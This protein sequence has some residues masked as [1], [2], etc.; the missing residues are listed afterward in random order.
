[1]IEGLES[2]LSIWHCHVCEVMC[3]EECLVC[4]DGID[5]KT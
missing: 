3:F 1:V 4:I 5:S 2:S